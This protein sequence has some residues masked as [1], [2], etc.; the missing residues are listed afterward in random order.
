MS[1]PKLSVNVECGKR[2][3]DM[4]AG[5]YSPRPNE[6]CPSDESDTDTDYFEYTPNGDRPHIINSVPNP[7]LDEVLEGIVIRL[8]QFFRRYSERFGIFMAVCLFLHAMYDIRQT[9]RRLR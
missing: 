9:I 5:Q 3:V 1:K 2:M 8:M 7:R 4:F 6:K